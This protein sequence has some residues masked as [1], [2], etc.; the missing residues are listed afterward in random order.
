[1]KWQKLLT[2]KELAHMRW[3]RRNN[4]APTLWA[5]ECLR[6]EQHRLEARTGGHACYECYE[7]ER[8]LKAGSKL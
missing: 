7:I 3:A 6:I 4:Q 5:F 8:K 2:K 1:M